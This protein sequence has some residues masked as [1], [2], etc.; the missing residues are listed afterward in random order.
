MASSA[1]AELNAFRWWRP[2]TDDDAGRRQPTGTPTFV[3]AHTVAGKGI[4]AIEG[5]AA[6]HVGY[7][8]GPDV[9]AA[10]ETIRAVHADLL[11][12]VPS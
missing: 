3:L 2:G 10:V 6:W 1:W 8:H 11:E 5:D 4:P 9:D 7:L 12:E